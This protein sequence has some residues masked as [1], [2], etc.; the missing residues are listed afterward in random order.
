VQVSGSSLSST[1]VGAG[2][3]A[4]RAPE[5]W[6]GKPPASPATDVYSL[7]CMLVEMLT[8][9]TLFDGSTPDEILTQH[10]I[11]GPTL[12][13]QF[14]ADCPAGLREIVLK[15]L[16]KDPNARHKD[17]NGVFDDLTKA[18]VIPAIKAEPVV[19][20]EVSQPAVKEPSKSEPINVREMRLDLGDGVTMEFVYV[21]AGKFLMGSDP[22]ID[23][24]A[25]LDEQPQQKIVLDEFMIGKYPVTTRQFNQF[26][27][28]TK[29]I[30]KQKWIN[31]GVENP[32][33]VDISWH[34]AN[35][36]C[37]W[38]SSRT[39]KRIELPTEAQWEKAA[40]GTDGR[41]YPWG[42]D[43][44][45]C[46]KANYLGCQGTIDNIGKHTMGVSPYG[47][48]DMLGNVWE[49]TSDWYRRDYYAIS[50]VSINPP[51]PALTIGKKVVR[52]GCWMSYPHT[53]RSA[54]RDARPPDN[55]LE[56][57]G[58]RCAL[59]LS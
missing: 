35:E 26:V 34:E 51:G 38:L 10:L 44:P 28:E 27:S 58:F 59:L 41:I 1:S 32:P 8:G 25:E 47:A 39:G 20:K 33:I 23:K 22:K 2:T 11:D 18:S 12:P 46:N 24:F 5:L 40:R 55:H 56:F 36:F 13:E 6:R 57:I 21:P 43:K 54:F 48:Q 3:P 52:G 29:R 9:K 50:G 4:Y 31:Q 17:A 53:L 37:G 19:L 15:G 49:W 42:N 16:S 45:D 14:P 7:A 30:T